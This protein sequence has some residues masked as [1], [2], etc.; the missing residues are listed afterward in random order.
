M[1]P[2]LIFIGTFRSGT[3]WIYNILVHHPDIFIPKEKELMFFSHHYNRGIKWYE[4]FY[5]DYRDQKYACDISPSYLSF[6]F[7]PERINKHIPNTKLIATL[8]NPVEQIWSLYKLWL[9]RNY[10]SLDLLNVLQT[11]DEFLN[12][13]LY[14][15]HLTRYQKYFPKDNMLILFYDDLKNDPLAYLDTIYAFL[16]INPL[17]P[18]AATSSQNATRSPRFLILDQL[19]AKAGDYLRK[20]GFL[21]FKV[22]VQRYFQIDAIRK[23]NTV[24][25]NKNDLIDS[26]VVQYISEYT[27]DDKK[28]LSILTGRDLSNWD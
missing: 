3:S 15:K 17:Y 26:E 14:F 22:F 20:K 28:N 10:T 1:L 19:I 25:N 6:D 9:I 12:N 27:Y 5:M 16:E 13:V 21:K 8:R 18:K 23:I 2:N 24:S 7:V 11:E 4:S